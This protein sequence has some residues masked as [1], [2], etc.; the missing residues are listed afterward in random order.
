M[1]CRLLVTDSR[2][3]DRLESKRNPPSR[4]APVVMREMRTWEEMPERANKT[5]HKTRKRRDLQKGIGCVVDQTLPVVRWED[6]SA[7]DLIA[8][9]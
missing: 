4:W 7:N 8:K 2:S 6:L 5:N 1:M 9:L 3:I